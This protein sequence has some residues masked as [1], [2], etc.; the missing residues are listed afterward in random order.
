MDE[1]ASTNHN[2]NEEYEDTRNTL[3]KEIQKKMKEEKYFIFVKSN[4]KYL[5]QTNFDMKG[6]HIM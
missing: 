6:V 1:Y 3:L 2:G 4:R 5:V